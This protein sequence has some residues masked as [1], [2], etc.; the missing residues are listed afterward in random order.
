MSS[1]MECPSRRT[2]AAMATAGAL[3]AA[4]LSGCGGDGDDNGAGGSGMTV[5]SPTI[6]AG[7]EIPATHACSPGDAESPQLTFAGVPAE[8]TTLALVMRDETIRSTHWVVVDIPVATTEVAAGGSPDPTVAAGRQAIES[9][10]GTKAAAT[11]RV[12]ETR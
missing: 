12:M 10:S 5:T 6:D 11:R 1:L 3:L 4:G 9:T 7:G 8:A 2:V